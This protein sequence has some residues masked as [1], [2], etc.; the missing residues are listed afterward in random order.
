M[1]TSSDVWIEKKTRILSVSSDRIHGETRMVTFALNLFDRLHLG[2]EVMIDRLVEMPEPIAG[3]TSGELVGEGLQLEEII[4]PLDVRVARLKNYLVKTKLDDIVE[5]KP[6]SKR[7]DL[8]QVKEEVT[9]IMYEGP[10]CTEIQSGALAK[11]KE[12]LG[13]TDKIEF[14]KPVRADDGDKIASARIRLGQIDRSGRRLRGTNE[15]PRLL[16]MD[17]RS[18][19]KSPK[20]D[21]FH[22]KEGAP[23]KRVI[24]RIMAESPAQVISVGDV[25]TATLVKEG[26]TP[27]VMIVDG[28]TK[29]GSY[30]SKFSAAIEFLIYNPAATI[31][32][33]AWSTI[34]T[35]I[36]NEEPTL[37]NVDGEEDLLGFP[38]VLLAPEESV[39][40]YGQP[41]VGIVWVP[42]NQE[43]QKLARSLLEQMSIIQ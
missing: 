31:Y 7:E 22:M 40:L 2:H 5:V 35:A 25:T 28:I 32:P 23:E 11:R 27:H 12:I 20:G 17:G 14:L 39:I 21:V 19:L 3:V 42:V 30:E 26:Y 37:V 29:R 8:L 36:G 41:D 38:A 15:P 18:R 34:A 24:E 4:Q 6:L 13:L 43:N 16:Q 33:E 1:L 9:F 10:C